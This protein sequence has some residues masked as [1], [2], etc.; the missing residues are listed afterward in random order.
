MPYLTWD[1]KTMSVGVRALD[2]DHKKIVALI[3]ALFFHVKSLPCQESA[4]KIIDKL[5]VLACEHFIHEEQLFAQTGYPDA[6]SHAAKHAEMAE[7]VIAFQQEYKNNPT[8]ELLFK[9]AN[10]LWNWLV[11]HDLT[12]DKKYG[13]YLNSK[14]IT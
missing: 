12:F 4:S 3:D 5:V 14:G 9:E 10:F 11:D 13:P 6:A 2:D 1:E 7:H 8:N